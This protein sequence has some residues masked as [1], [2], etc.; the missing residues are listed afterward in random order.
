MAT[1]KQ[2]LE[3]HLFSFIKENGLESLQDKFIEALT[4]CEYELDDVIERLVEN[5]KMN[6]CKEL[7]DEI[8]YLQEELHNLEQ[9]Y[10]VQKELFDFFEPK[11]LQ[12]EFKI[13]W[14]KDNWDNIK[15][16]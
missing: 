14:V 7:E 13:Q 9:D 16:L 15:P 12:D 10:K 1:L 11:T 8:D 4:K 5:E 2:T 3:K 6:A